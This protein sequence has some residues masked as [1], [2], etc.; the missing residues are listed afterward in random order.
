MNSLNLPFVEPPASV[1]EAAVHPDPYPFYAA[2]LQGPPLVF[3]PD[4]RFWIAARSS[5]IREALA[6]PVLRVRP[7]GQPVLPAIAGTAAGEVFGDLVRMNDGK[8]HAAPKVALSA[9]LSRVDLDEV[10]QKAA[11]MAIAT[12]NGKLASARELTTWMLDLPVMTVA[13]LLGFADEECPHIA[14]L[15]A[16]FAACLSPHTDVA[17]LQAASVAAADLRG[18]LAQK[19]ADTAAI[20]GSALASLQEEAR[21]SGWTDAGAVLSNLTG[22]LSQTFEATAGLLGNC[23]VALANHSG[24]LQAVRSGPALR[25]QLVHEVGRHDPSIHNTRRFAAEATTLAGVALKEGDA[26]VLLLGAAGRDPGCHPQPDD[27]L[28]HR[29]NRPTPAFGGG[30]HQCPGQAVASHV[31]AGALDGW[32]D[33]TGGQLG[34]LPSSWHY[35]PSLNARVPVFT[36]FRGRSSTAS[37]QPY[38]YGQP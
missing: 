36:A 29:P 9:F 14:R 33:V 13:S 24:L 5:V 34:A 18:R 6:N 8:R 22:L 25:L 3:D 38:R 31:V 1:L 20:R 16:G 19:V 11:S 27:L 21:R 37:H 26:V 28:L 17:G 4:Q 15:T 23:L 32:L 30:R 7:V 35:R 10:R 12:A 2:L